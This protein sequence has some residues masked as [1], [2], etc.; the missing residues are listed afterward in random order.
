MKTEVQL[1]SKQITIEDLKK[2]DHLGFIAEKLKWEIIY[3]PEGYN[4]ITWQPK[5]DY[6]TYS[7][8]SGDPTFIDAINSAHRFY[9]DLL[10]YRFDTRKELY[11]WLAE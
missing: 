10:L 3:T 2:G 4:S 8:N 6:C 9:P 7:I 11:Q 5:S 1:T